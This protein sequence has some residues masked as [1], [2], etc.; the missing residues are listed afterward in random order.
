MGRSLHDVREILRYAQNDAA[1]DFAV[2]L[3]RRSVEKGFLI[4]GPADRLTEW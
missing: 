2:L 4:L 3:H 1:L